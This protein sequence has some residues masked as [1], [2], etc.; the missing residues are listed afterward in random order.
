M[1]LAQGQLNLL[2]TCP[3]K[4]QHL[5]LDRLSAPTTPE[6][7]EALAWGSRFHLLMQQ[8]ELGLPIDA[9][10]EEFA[11]E[12]QHLQQSL[13]TFIA[14]VPEVFQADPQVNRQSE[15]RCT[16][17]FEGYMLTVIYDLL[18][19]DEQ[20]AQILD[21]KTHPR[22]QQ[23][24]WL[25]RNWQTRLYSYVLAETSAYQ[26]EQISMTYWFVRTEA[27]QTQPQSLRFDYSTAQHEQTRQDLTQLLAQLTDW[28]QGYSQGE[29]FPQVAPTTG[30]C[31]PCHFLWRCERG[32][33]RGVEAVELLPDLAQI[34]EVVL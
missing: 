33:A 34:Q 11:L 12:D 21:W 16:L 26:P 30:H 13:Q 28:L 32:S 23:R 5:Y 25:A 20:Q 8:R 31:K 2:A 22:P 15:F 29:P 27:E 3:R 1:R 6:Q 19:S 10:V 9:Q 7:Q 24:H 18:L 4:F 14:A 17:N